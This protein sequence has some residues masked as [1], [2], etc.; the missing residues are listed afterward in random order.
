MNIILQYLSKSAKAHAEKFE[1]IR[2]TEFSRAASDH[3]IPESFFDLSYTGADGTS[4]AADIYRPAVRPAKLPVII[5]VHGGGLFTG[6]RKNNRLFCELTAGKGFL[7]YALQYRLIGE[8]DAFSEISDICA[9]L[10]FVSSTLAQYGGDPDR[11]FLLGESAGAF[12]ALYAAAA[13][14]SKKLRRLLGCRPPSLNL[15][16]FIAFSGMFY[17][18]RNDVIGMVYKKA[19]YG[20][21]SRD[22]KF[23]K[24]MDPAHPEVLPNL[25]PLFLT[26]SDADF[27]KSYT[28]RFHKAAKTAGHSCTLIFYP[29]GKEL[30]HAFVSLRPLLYES[31]KTLDALCLWIKDLPSPDIQ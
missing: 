19:L 30:T 31:R 6:T 25:P 9:G 14:R 5:L 15:C 12:L 27:L 2:N 18:A 29:E 20:E 11:V 13:I 26:S 16:G 22:R 23:L 24:Y 17:T 8:A 4:L 28:L 10:S 3:E 1:S 21:H 7:L